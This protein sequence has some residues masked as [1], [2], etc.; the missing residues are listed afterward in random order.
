MYAY[1]TKL[2]KTQEAVALNQVNPNVRGTG[3]GEARHREYKR[4]KPGGGRT[5][6]RSAD[7]LPELM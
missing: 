2:C 7:S 5:Y 4:L 6:D 1:I 3:Q